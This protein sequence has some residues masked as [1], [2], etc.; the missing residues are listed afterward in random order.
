[1]SNELIGVIEPNKLKINVEIIGA[2][3]PGTSFKIKGLFPTLEDLIDAHPQGVL[4][5][6]YAVGTES[7]NVIYIW[8]EDQ[9]TW[10][11]IGSVQ[12]PPGSDAE[13]TEANIKAAL[14]YTP[15]DEQDLTSHLAET[16][17]HGAT[18]EATANRLMLRDAIGSVKFY[19]DIV[20]QNLGIAFYD[21]G[22]SAYT[23]GQTIVSE[24]TLSNG[25][26]YLLFTNT[27]INADSATYGLYLVGL[28]G[29]QK[30]ITPILADSGG[31]S[32]SIN[33]DNKIE[34][35]NASGSNRSLQFSLIRVR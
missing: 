8:S 34:I 27:G 31:I 5:D 28:M 11:N 19:S 7:Q 2:G 24:K 10:V 13:V 17:P 30:D 26:L 16:A 35:T 21:A 29:T 18:S 12:G 1:M 33:A 9:T 20:L 15:A 6:A 23:T 22:I 3:P 4:G 14:G 25:G 32:V